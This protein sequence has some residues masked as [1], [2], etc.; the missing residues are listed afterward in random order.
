MGG[1][2]FFILGMLI[3][4]GIFAAV[5]LYI[6]RSQTELQQAGVPVNVEV[7]A[8]HASRDSDGDVTY[9][10]EFRIT[11]GIHK[12]KRWKST[13]S[14]SPA[15]HQTGDRERG[16]FDPDSGKIQSVSLNKDGMYFSPI[17]SS[18]GLGIMLSGIIFWFRARGL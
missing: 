9:A 4:G 15:A 13:F 5:G 6:E 18:I 7:I 12:D 8:M 11:S 14:S 1:Y 2:W 3:F 16:Y 17:F 10:P